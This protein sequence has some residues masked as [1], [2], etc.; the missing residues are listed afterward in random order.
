MNKY[1]KDIFIHLDGIAMCPIYELI[2]NKY[3]LEE[4]FHYFD[5]EKKEKVN[6]AYFSILIKILLAQKIIRK[7]SVNENL[8]NLTSRGENLIKNNTFSGIQAYYKESISLLNDSKYNKV[9]FNESFSYLYKKWKNSSL[10]LENILNKHLEGALIAPIVIYLYRKKQ[11]NDSI[12]DLI[13]NK[14][15]IEIIFFLK[16]INFIDM[17]ALTEKGNYIL[18]RSYAYGVTASYLPAVI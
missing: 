1:L 16:N 2:I 4:S 12:I 9:K 11:N 13:K 8:Y 14:F 18:S 3:H 17:N 10:P 7:D 5:M 15:D 6:N